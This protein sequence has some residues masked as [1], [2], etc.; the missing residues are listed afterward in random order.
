[1]RRDER[2]GGVRDVGG[3]SSSGVAAGGGG[4]RRNG[5]SFGRRRRV[6]AATLPRDCA[7]DL[8]VEG[9]PPPKGGKSFCLK[10]TSRKVVPQLMNW[11]NSEPWSVDAL[12]RRR[13]VASLSPLSLFLDEAVA[14][15]LPTSLS[16]APPRV[17]LL[18]PSLPVRLPLP[19]QRRCTSRLRSLPR[20][21]PPWAG[22]PAPP[23]PTARPL[24]GG[25]TVGASTGTPPPRWPRYDRPRR[26]RP[27]APPRPRPAVTAH[28]GLSPCD[29]HQRRPPAA[30]GPNANPPTSPLLFCFFL[31]VLT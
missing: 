4:R 25:G 18:F 9:G 27:S 11:I 15:S 12:V 7:Q 2:C 21:P 23:P 17:L 30:T 22:A 14:S 26:R 13:L 16:F 10:Y 8:E 28:G 3:G 31:L 6:A 20:P 19:L 29:P 24:G 5:P 1:M